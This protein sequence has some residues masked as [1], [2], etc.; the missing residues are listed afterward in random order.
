MSEDKAYKLNSYP[1]FRLPISLI[2]AGLLLFVVV[3]RFSTTAVARSADALETA[4]TPIIDLDGFGTLELDYSGATFIE[5]QGPVIIVPDQLDIQAD[6]PNISS[7]SIK[8][9][10][11]PDGSQEELD[12]NVTGFPAI[13]PSY[14][15]A[16]GLLLT[17]PDTISNFI[18]V[19]KTATYANS[20][21]TPDPTTRAVEFT[22]TDPV[23]VSLPATSHVAIDP[24]NYAPKLYVDPRPT[25]LILDPI[26]E[27]DQAPPGNKVETLISSAEATY[28]IDLITDPD[29]NDPEG[30]AVIEVGDTNGTWEYS[31]DSR[32]TWKEFGSVKDS[33][34]RL[35]DL[36]AYVRFVPK[37]NFSGGSTF[38]FRAWDHTTTKTS[39]D[40]ADASINGGTT[41]FSKTTEDANIEVKA[42]NANYPPVV[43]IAEN[44]IVEFIEGQGP[45]IV[46]GPALQIVDVDNEF[47]QSA[48]ATIKNLALN[49]PDVLKA[50]TNGT[51]IVEDYDSVTGTL[52]L[53]G[54]ATVSDYQTVL[55]SVTF[56]NLSQDPAVDVRKIRNIGFAVNDGIDLSNE[57]IGMVQVEAVNDPP[58]LD[59][60]GEG[61]G[62]DNTVF[63]DK[64]DSGKGGSVPLASALQVQ[65]VDDTSLT[66]AKVYLQNRPDGLFE[67]LS[68][69]NTTGTNISAMH[70]DGS[71]VIEFS[72]Q[73]SLM[74][75]EKVLRSVTYTN[76][77]PRADRA[78]R[79]VLFSVEDASSGSG[80]AIANVI[81]LPQ[82]VLLPF[83][84]HQEN[85]KA[86]I[87]EPNDSCDEAVSIAANTDYHFG[88]D[89]VQDWFSFTLQ[90][91]ASVKVELAE[92]APVD[93]QLAVGKGECGSLELIKHNGDSKTSKMVDLGVLEAGRYFVLVTNDGPTNLDEPYKLRV[94]V[95]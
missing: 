41:A 39:G 57:A 2:L 74:A 75:Y 30:I 10:A 67:A 32:I 48:T 29:V 9:V 23:G 25:P 94:S 82:Y 55:R 16:T 28:G 27:N 37:P 61:S 85:D 83:I 33:S 40:E 24:D 71:G 17:G 46:A 77:S 8:L 43:T 7:A 76:R 90:N 20:S 81:V 45:V 87:E 36:S 80:T 93:G 73:D 65:D 5:G 13:E 31:I 50:I 49:E 54:E 18:A 58:L 53:S 89:D 62:F 72:G 51:G 15:P 92:F 56:D 11:N 12:V 34:A 86:L 26:R 44:T 52:T 47:L 59:L 6:G 35:L 78:T 68:A 1:G 69:D 4:A 63:F 64:D 3:S 42:A 60:N 88:A 91:S 79:E 66:G 84:V 95:N 14:D 38:V 22:I 21:Q 70:S 19:L